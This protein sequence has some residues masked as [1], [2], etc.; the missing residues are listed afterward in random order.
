MTTN[1]AREYFRRT[2][3]LVDNMTNTLVNDLLQEIKK[4]S[5][6]GNF[7]YQNEQ[8]KIPE[9]VNKNVIKKLEEDGFKVEC[10]IIKDPQE[11]LVTSRITVFW[12]DTA[13]KI[14]AKMYENTV[15]QIEKE[16]EV[17]FQQILNQIEEAHSNCQFSLYYGFPYNYFCNAKKV[18]QMIVESGFP[19]TDHGDDDDPYDY[20]T[21]SW[22]FV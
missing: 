17:I 19:I 1:L 20:F 21:I 3:E 4:R 12:N 22:S 5:D 15:K 11:I 9:I 10:Q 13:T 18:K 16:N 14:A 2:N 8:H 7:S 6:I